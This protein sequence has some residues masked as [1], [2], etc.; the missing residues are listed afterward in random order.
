MQ[1]LECLTLQL[2]H[3]YRLL[4]R[5]VEGLTCEQAT[6][7]LSPGRPSIAWLLG[8]LTYCADSVAV[9][10]GGLSP[11]L[12]SEFLQAHR[13]PHWG[14]A[15]EARWRERPALWQEVSARTLAS[16]AA[17]GDADLDRPPATTI[18]ERFR[19]SLAT[20]AAFLA[21]HVFHVAYHLGQAGSL[22][23]ELGLPWPE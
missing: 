18:H 23:A 7:R 8:H 5:Q 19:D 22:R 9:A 16:L 21:G 20:R 6:L 13:Q 10:V 11:S 4:S 17:L 12:S 3:H 2:R 14:V 1:A 15:D